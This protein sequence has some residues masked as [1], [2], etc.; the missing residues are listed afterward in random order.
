MNDVLKKKEVWGPWA[1]FGFALLI[2][3][4]VTVVQIIVMVIYLIVLKV[5]DPSLELW[6]VGRNLGE[7][8]LFLSVATI[9]S[10]PISV[11]LTF[12]ICWLRRGVRIRDYL[13]LRR[14]DAKTTFFCIGI[15][16][17]VALLLDGLCL[18]I[19]HPIPEFM[20]STYQSAGSLPLFWIVICVVAPISEELLFRGFFYKGLSRSRL[21]VAGAIIV[22]SLC[23][24]IIHLQYDIFIIATIFVHG[25]VL[26]TARAKTRSVVPAILMH[27]AINLVAMIQTAIIVHG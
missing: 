13:A 11:G 16:L 24:A 21:G 3:I 6:S 9:I 19:K 27:V 17:T 18:I 4:V 22:I 5:L 7:S 14:V 15:V 10:F 25:L 2:G 8:G 23:W 1:T 12:L 26:G 20:I